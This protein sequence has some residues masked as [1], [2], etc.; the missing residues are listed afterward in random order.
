M[1]SGLPLT[2]ELFNA[3]LKMLGYTPR[4][5]SKVTGIDERNT[6]RWAKSGGV[7]P[8]VGLL[9]VALVRLK[10]THNDTAFLDNL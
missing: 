8:S 4:T 2:K 10:Y 7:P 1:R 9:I 3:G 5:F 6:R